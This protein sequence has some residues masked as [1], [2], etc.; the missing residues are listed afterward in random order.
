MASF[1]LHIQSC[2]SL[3]RSVGVG[4]GQ[5]T[6]VLRSSAG[7]SI[8][9]S[10]PAAAAVVATPTPAQHNSSSATTSTVT[11]LL[12][13]GTRYHHSE[14][15]EH[16]DPLTPH[17]HHGRGQGRGHAAARAHHVRDGLPVVQ[18]G[19][20]LSLKRRLCDKKISQSRR[21]PLLGPSPSAFTFKT[22]LRHYAKQST[23][24]S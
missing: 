17:Q 8:P 9:R 6:A 20:W 12:S 13:L 14:H 1:S 23:Q 2:Y 3:P 16:G 22:L 7:H 24:R 15:S 5:L 4:G 19:C 11:T 18:V 21:R 10:G